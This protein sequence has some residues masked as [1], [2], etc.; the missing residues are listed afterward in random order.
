MCFIYPNKPADKYSL[1]SAAV[2]NALAEPMREGNKQMELRDKENKENK[3]RK[4]EST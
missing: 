4:K 2:F 1:I 3:K